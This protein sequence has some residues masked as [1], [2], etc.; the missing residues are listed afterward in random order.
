MIS[1]NGALPEIQDFIKEQAQIDSR[2]KVINYQQNIFVI[3]DPELRTYIFAMMRW[4]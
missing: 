3:K 1:N 4:I 2:I